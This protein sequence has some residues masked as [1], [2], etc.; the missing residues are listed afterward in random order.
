LKVLPKQVEMERVPDLTRKCAIGQLGEP[1][2]AEP[3]IRLELRG[4]GNE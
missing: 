3:D 1:L 4:N 2:K